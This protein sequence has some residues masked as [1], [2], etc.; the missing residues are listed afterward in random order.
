MSKHF[1]P[2]IIKCGL[3]S[4]CTNVGSYETAGL[5]QI[6]QRMKI[7]GCD[8]CQGSW[9]ITTKERMLCDLKE[10]LQHHLIIDDTSQRDDLTRGV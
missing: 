2:L 10:A 7:G 5:N 3:H 1:Y 4:S 6:Q 8:D 9:I